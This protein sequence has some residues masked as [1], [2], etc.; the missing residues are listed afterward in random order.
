MTLAVVP[1]VDR[2][3]LSTAVCCAF[4]LVRYDPM[5]KAD[6]GVT[7]AMEDPLAALPWPLSELNPPQKIC[8][9]AC[10]AVTMTALH[11]GPY[12]GTE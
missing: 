6:S 4:M 1:I 9:T 2:M 3:S 5:E 11:G 10:V 8:G 7:A 12:A